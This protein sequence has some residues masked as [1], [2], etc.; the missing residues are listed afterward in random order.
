MTSAAVRVASGR[1]LVAGALLR[2]AGWV[3]V[4]LVGVAGVRIAL[5]A[6][7]AE[8]GYLVPVLRREWV[9][10]VIGP[11]EPYGLIAPMHYVF[12]E[13]A[14]MTTAYATAV[15][16][17]PRISLWW[18]GAAVV[19]LHVTFML[20][21]PLLSTDVFNYIDV[22]RLGGRYHLN[23]YVATP[24]WRPHDPVY[25]FVH[26]RHAVT[27]YGPL[28]TLGVRP[29][30]RLSVAEA[31]WWFKAIAAIA[32]LG[33][34][35][36]VGWIAHQRGTS[37]AR[38]VAAFGLNPIVLVWT[39]GGAHNDLVMLLALLAGVSLVLARKPAA[40]GAALVTA[41]A[42]KLSAGLA[43]PFLLLARG[44]GRRRLWLLAGVGVSAAVVVGV[45]YV[46][47]PDH[48]LGMVAKLQRQEAL[49]SI[50]SVPVGIAY[51]LHLPTVSPQEAHYLHLLLIVWIAG[52]LVYV[53][54]GGDAVAAAGWALLGVITASSWLL[55]WYLVW[56]L[57]LAAA[58]DRRRLLVATC[59]VGAAYAIG[60]AP[61]F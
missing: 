16:C 1:R 6:A 57:A 28:F 11:L 20:A 46:T 2:T 13:V 22:A 33:C 10:S 4:V 41:T 52:L 24:A 53:A 36:L 34:T 25:V 32:G 21:P 55:P 39:V 8:H 58:T 27:D 44:Q 40:G 14:L 29:L 45:T 38:A 30:G 50:A 37:P 31:L 49:V 18:I 26:W 56:P 9:P 48:A 19:V 54:R 51:A 61:L 15:V 59:A 42:I 60:H 7:A 35:A 23:P 3:A 12:T 47:F 17:A 5:V 43:I